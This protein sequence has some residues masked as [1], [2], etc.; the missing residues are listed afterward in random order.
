MRPA[1][2][3]TALLVVLA[4]CGG[5][6]DVAVTE[7]RTDA[8]ATP[9][10]TPATDVQVIGG[11]LPLD[12][13][14]VF[15]RV[16]NLTGERVAGP[17][18]YVEPPAEMSSTIL[19]GRRSQFRTA[20]GVVPP[21]RTDAE[22]LQL[23]AYAPTD[24]NAVHVNEGILGDETSAEVTVAHEFVH[25]VQFRNGWHESVWSVDPAF[26]AGGISYDRELTYYLV[27][28]GAGEY[29]EDHYVRQF[30]PGV[31][32]EDPL[33]A[34]YRDG[35]AYERLN[36][37]RYV[38]G[39]EYVA[40]RVDSPRE[41]AGVHRHPPESSEQVLHNS[42]DPVEHL[43]VTTSETGDW[44]EHTRNRQGELFLRVALRTELNRSTAVDAAHGW[45]EDRR[46]T[47]ERGNK[48]GTAWT[49]HWDDAANATEF[50]AAFERF[51]D[52]KA[53]ERD[54]VWYQSDGNATYR[55]V[56]ANDETTVVLLGDEAFVRAATVEAT[57]DGVLDIEI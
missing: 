7:P 35:S 46:I 38:L 29:V 55:V 18:V 20:L 28:E 33:R 30:V 49:L 6:A 25:V 15:D 47:F 40:E 11:E 31:D 21:A 56:E 22:R 9:T 32:G 43:I 41:L 39:A 4:G 45:G 36:L 44:T 53:I 2:V 54:G 23:A 51:L 50:E 37:A 27:I 24:G 42:T 1:A 17:V 8:T 14:V 13:T 3:L 12:A 52:A 57:R 5:V 19:D 48:T 34:D 26:D 16:L 10:A